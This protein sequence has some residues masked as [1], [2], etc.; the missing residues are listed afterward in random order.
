LQLYFKVEN[1]TGQLGQS[2][3]G[4]AQCIWDNSN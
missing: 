1:F 4:Q 2:L 3:L